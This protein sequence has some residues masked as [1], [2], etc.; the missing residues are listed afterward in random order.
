MAS[1]LPTSPVAHD[2]AAFNK[3]G[4]K[5]AKTDEKNPLPS[6]EGIYILYNIV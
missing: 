3:E 6:S 1:E 2:I 5:H 4:L